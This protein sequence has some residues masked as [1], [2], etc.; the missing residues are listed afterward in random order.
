M[1]NS[2]QRLEPSFKWIIFKWSKWKTGT[3]KRYSLKSCPKMCKNAALLLFLKGTAFRGSTSNL[4]ELIAPGPWHPQSRPWDLQSSPHCSEVQCLC[5]VQG[6]DL[7]SR[8]GEPDNASARGSQAK[9]SAKACRF[10]HNLNSAV[11]RFMVALPLCCK[12]YSCT[13]A[14]P[15]SPAL[16]A[17]FIFFS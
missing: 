2:F 6:R 5:R 10:H 14:S 3:W 16:G 13:L 1:L 15:L 12:V 7:T 17:S 4:R 8:E 11:W 9:P